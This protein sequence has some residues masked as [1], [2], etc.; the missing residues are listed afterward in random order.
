MVTMAKGLG[1]GAPIAAVVT[2]KEIADSMLGKIFFNTF[3]GNPISTTMAL[4][5]L[6][7]MDQIDV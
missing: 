3:G 7:V 1:N 4:A 5:T 6:E 2:R